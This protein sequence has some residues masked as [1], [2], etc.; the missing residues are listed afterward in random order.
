[1]F[2]HILI[3]NRGEAALR[4]L[5]TC[6]ALGVRATLAVS[7]VDRD[8][9]PARLADRVVCIGPAAPGLSYLNGAALT[10]AALAV[11]AQAIHPGYGFLAESAAFA[12]QVTQAGLVFVGPPADA[13]ARLG[14]KAASRALA[15]SVGAPVI[16][17]SEPLTDEVAARRAAD[18]LGYPVLLKAAA[19]GG[20]RGIRRVDDGAALEAQFVAARAEAAGAFG[21]GALYME[22]LLGHARHVEVQ[23]LADGRGHVVAL[24]ERDC[25]AQRRRQ[26]V[27]EET[28]APHLP[29]ATR[30]A[31]HAAAGRLAQAAGYVNAG[32][33]EFLVDG[34]GQFYFMEMNA[35]LQV[36]HP[37][38]EMVT[39]MDLVAE[40]LRVAA[41]EADYGGLR[42]APLGWAVEARVT[43]EDPD[44]DFLP[45]VGTVTRYQP[46]SGPGVRVDSHL[47]TGY[48]IPLWYD[49]LLAKVIAWGPDRPTAVAR[50]A[51]ALGEMV[52][53]GAPTT[54]PLLRRLVDSPAF[55]QG[56]VDTEWL[57]RET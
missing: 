48:A 5:R 38:T 14:D 36:E 25:S 35:R 33:V 42:L 10:Q 45:R 15:V 18:D 32:T 20:G 24:G 57:Q 30:D 39:G 17:G 47:Y 12:R 37:V 54:L 7:D 52:I 8:S 21:D 50:L 44:H 34:D 26:K 19:G 41:G 56:G 29:T 49:S 28:P 27:L 6:H 55:R 2:S 4:I 23:I 40:Q 3:A 1:M 13:M 43:A 22:K 16:P 53:K 11:G 46:P 51:G 31:L 9:L